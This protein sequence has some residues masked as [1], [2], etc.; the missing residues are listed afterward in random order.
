MS[1]S[2]PD[3]AAQT[4]FRGV[5]VAII[6]D[7]DPIQRRTIVLVIRRPGQNWE[8]PTDNHQIGYL[9]TDWTH[10]K[11]I[12]AGGW[13]PY[14]AK[15]AER[16]NLKLL[17]VFPPTTNP[18]TPPTTWEEVPVALGKAFKWAPQPDNTLKV[19]VA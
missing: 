1:Y 8:M 12:A 9:E 11:V 14:L 13:K 4:T 2:V 3:F 5:Q 16:A 10:E 17:D 15:I 18:G 19:E 6:A 7:V